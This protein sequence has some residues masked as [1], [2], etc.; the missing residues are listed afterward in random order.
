MNNLVFSIYLNNTFTWKGES[1]DDDI[2]LS[3]IEIGFWY[4]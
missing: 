4:I 3:F 1:S 2:F